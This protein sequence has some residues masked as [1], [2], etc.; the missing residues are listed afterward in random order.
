MAN[1]SSNF[2]Q[3]HDPR[4]SGNMVDPRLQVSEPP[5]S[6]VGMM[7]PVSSFLQP[8]ES[9]DQEIEI[10]AAGKKIP[11]VLRPITIDSRPG[12][13]SSINLE[14]LHNSSDPRLQ[15]YLNHNQTNAKT[16]SGNNEMDSSDSVVPAKPTDPRLSKRGG[17]GGGSEARNPGDVESG[18][19]GN[20]GTKQQKPYTLP[21]IVLPVLSTPVQDKTSTVK[22]TNSTVSTRKAALDDPAPRATSTS[23][24]S[25]KPV[26]KTSQNLVELPEALQERNFPMDGRLSRQSSTGSVGHVST[27]ADKKVIDYRNDPRYK[28]KKT[29]P[30]LEEL[31]VVQPLKLGKVK[32][33]SASVKEEWTS[34]HNTVTEPVASD[35]STSKLPFGGNFKVP[36]QEFAEEGQDAEAED[37]DSFNPESQKSEATSVHTPVNFFEGVPTSS[38]LSDVEPTQELNLKDMFK[39]IDPT[40]SPFC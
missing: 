16:R 7:M 20:K 38:I 35:S 14:N 30:L 29:K 37:S 22:V 25:I 9:P 19:N 27:N 36:H 32:E 34:E 2:N 13:P 4:T 18:N 23:P 6:D 10:N 40:T 39:T 11:Y 24:P 15:K 26:D 3:S 33:E 17:G 8:P 5:P 21:D 28:K 31:S 12:P 1:T